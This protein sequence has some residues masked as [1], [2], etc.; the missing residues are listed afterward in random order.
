M[1]S[2]GT[3][4]GFWN[5]DAY[6]ARKEQWRRAAGITEQTLVELPSLPGTQP[7]R[8][9]QFLQPQPRQQS[10]I[11]QRG[12]SLM[13]RSEEC[14]RPLTRNRSRSKSAPSSSDTQQVTEAFDKPAAPNGAKRSAINR[15]HSVSSC[16]ADKGKDNRLHGIMMVRNEFEVLR[17]LFR[18]Y[19]VHRTGQITRD[20]FIRE[21]ARLTPGI[22]DHA[23]SMFHAADRDGSGALDFCEFL[24]MYAPTLTRKQV[25]KLC[26]KYGGVYY[27]EDIAELCRTKEQRLKRDEQIKLGEEKMRLEVG[28]LQKAFAQWCR[29]G[30]TTISMKTLRGKCPSIKFEELDQWLTQYSTKGELDKDAFVSLC[31]HHYGVCVHDNAMALAGNLKREGWFSGAD[32]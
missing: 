21:V 9:K 15:R 18:E 17:E 24:R 10:L 25:T 4:R 31:S 28:E 6:Q 29:P 3:K 1:V 26:N 12:Q 5:A 20:D 2:F 13:Q 19:D 23:E 32:K 30:K 16:A 22:K 27:K 14:T 11:I 7:T 8:R